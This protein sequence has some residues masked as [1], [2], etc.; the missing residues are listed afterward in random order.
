MA[1]D[2][3]R[4]GRVSRAS[5]DH[6]PVQLRHHVTK[7]R[8]VG[9]FHSRQRGHYTGTI[10]EHS[11]HR[12][13]LI[14]RQFPPLAESAHG[15][16]HQQPGVACIPEKANQAARPRSHR[17]TVR[18]QTF[19]QTEH[20]TPLQSNG[21]QA[22]AYPPGASIVTI[23]EIRPRLADPNRPGPEGLA[24]D[25]RILTAATVQLSVP[26]IVGIGGVILL[27][28]PITLRLA[29]ATVAVLGGIG[30]VILERQRR[31]H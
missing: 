28:E 11:V 24:G 26:V 6:V 29:L 18:L 15:R 10:G 3:T 17:Y 20:G 7:A 1:P 4:P 8:E 16:N 5:A 22:L 14:R 27:S 31:R 21:F 12:R 13:A 25:P 19:I 30:L 23:G 2:R 9:F